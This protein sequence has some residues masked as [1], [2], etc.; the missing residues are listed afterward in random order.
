MRTA[1]TC[2]AIW[3]RAAQTSIDGLVAF[4]DFL[5]EW[6]FEQDFDARA[7]IDPAP[8]T[9]IDRQRHAWVA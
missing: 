5:V 1:R 4:K 2:T 8:F 9:R 7:W 6:A 3:R